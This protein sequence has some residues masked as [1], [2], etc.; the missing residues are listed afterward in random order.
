[1]SN[2]RETYARRE[3]RMTER[4]QKRETD[5][6]TFFHGNQT[7][8]EQRYMDYFETD[9]EEDPE[10]EYLETLNDERSIAQSG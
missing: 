9:L 6:Y 4:I 2:D 1:L 8:E 5:N 3:K 7:E 10:D